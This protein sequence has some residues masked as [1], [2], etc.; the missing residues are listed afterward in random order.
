M[1]GQDCSETVVVV[2]VVVVVV[3]RVVGDN[4][5]IAKTSSKVFCKS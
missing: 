1:K 3:G 4:G 2:V 5:A